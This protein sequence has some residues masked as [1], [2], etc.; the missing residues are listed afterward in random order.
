MC[1]TS[2]PSE[3]ISNYCGWLYFRGYQFSW[4]EQTLHISWVENSWPQHFPVKFIQK[5]VFF[6]DT[7]FCG[8][9]PLRNPRK[10]V[11]NEN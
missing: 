9:D 6:V 4:I 1:S 8:S 7:R 10:L 5:I 3:L 11:P 2:I